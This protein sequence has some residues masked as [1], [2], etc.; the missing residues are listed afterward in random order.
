MSILGYVLTSIRPEARNTPRRGEII[1]YLLSLNP[2]PLVCP[3]LKQNV[4]HLVW[5]WWSYVSNDCKNPCGLARS[6]M[7][8]FTLFQLC[9]HT[10]PI[11][12]DPENE[13]EGAFD[14]VMAV[15]EQLRAHFADP[16][17]LA[18]R[19]VNG[20]TPLH[21][22]A[23]S[24][25]IRGV[26]TLLMLRVPPN[27]K[28][29]KGMSPVVYALRAVHRAINLTDSGDADPVEIK[30]PEVMGPIMDLIYETWWAPYVQQ[31]DRTVVLNRVLKSIR[32]RR[33]GEGE[34]AEAEFITR[35]E[36]PTEILL[37]VEVAA[38]LVQ[39]C[40]AIGQEDEGHMDYLYSFH[41][42]SQQVRQTLGLRLIRFQGLHF[43]EED[44]IC[45]A[46]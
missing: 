40:R 5:A 9:S 46:D 24:G 44:D 41:I 7:F 33:Q 25:N 4:F 20:A 31:I 36:E 12:F 11:D 29:N 15:F 19:D 38:Y 1:R 45:S 8:P 10:C 39:S 14:E 16:S 6:T 13:P 2:D 23:S 42:P 27:P 17:L 43:P 3:E 26:Q 28:D 32:K 34:S 30:L 22:A 18:A 37:L 35:R 21:F